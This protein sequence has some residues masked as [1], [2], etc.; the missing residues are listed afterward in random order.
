MTG[1]RSPLQDQKRSGFLDILIEQEARR[2]KRWREFY[3]LQQEKHGKVCGWCAN[4]DVIN[5]DSEN[6][7]VC[8][9]CE[10]D[11]LEQNRQT[12]INNGIVNPIRQIYKEIKNIFKTLY[13]LYKRDY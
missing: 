9:S 1:M 3:R 6:G 2:Y 13:T 10:W 11:R 4:H 5:P 8:K 7:Y 12:T